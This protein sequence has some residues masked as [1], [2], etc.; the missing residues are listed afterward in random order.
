MG[1]PKGGN[2][3]SIKPGQTRNPNGQPKKEWSLTQSMREFMS[4]TDPELKQTKKDIFI[5]SQFEHALKGDPTAS[6]H[7]WQ[8]LDGMPKGTNPLGET[9]GKIIIEWGNGADSASDTSK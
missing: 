3:G 6:K 1:A 4:E 9:N 5:K 8:Y 7:L 2:R